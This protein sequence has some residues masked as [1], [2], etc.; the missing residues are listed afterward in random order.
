MIEKI[1]SGCRK[2]VERAAH[3]AA[4]KNGLSHGR[5]TAR[6]KM[7]EDG[8]LSGKI[9]LVKNEQGKNKQKEME[10]RGYQ[11]QVK[12]NVLFSDGVILFTH[13]DTGTD[14][15][16]VK[17]IAEIHNRPWFYIDLAGTTNFQA[18][19]EISSWIGLHRIKAL[20]VIGPFEGEDTLI[21][22]HV[23]NI[24]ESVIFMDQMQ[25][26]PAEYVQSHLH[27]PDD[28]MLPETVDEAVTTLLSK[29]SLKDR[30]TIANM[31]FD[32]L[33]SLH[34][35]IGR[36]IMN[37]FGLWIGNEKLMKSCCFTDGSTDLNEKEASDVIIGK[38]WEQLRKTHKLKLIKS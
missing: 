19:C 21:Y 16:F 34:S 20:A 3:D 2:G 26:V 9:G 38:L 22:N 11:K 29:L 6:G 35:S 18:V 28:F 12:Q 10:L 17:H 5:M 4:E 30:A 36:Y 14:S 27:R 15:E 32:E 31:T 37:V 13:E 25:T 8:I 7:T 23:V 33:D 1:I 24:L